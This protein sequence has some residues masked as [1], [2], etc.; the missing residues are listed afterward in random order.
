MATPRR[1]RKVVTVLFCDLVGFTSRAENLDPE[2]VADLLAGYHGRVRSDLER[3][4]G[5]VEKFIGDAVMAVFGAPTTHEDDPER[6]VRAALA[7][8]DWALEERDVQVRIAVNTGEA[9]VTIDARPEEGE[10]V[11]AGDV[12]NTAARLQAVSPVNSILV[13]ETTYRATRH[14]IDYRDSPPVT[15]KGKEEPVAVWEV[16]DARA[17]FGAEVLDHAAGELVGRERELAA[18][19]AALDRVR[20]ERS[21]QLVT[22]VGVPGIGKS[23]LLYELS[24]IA[25]AKPELITWRQGRCLAFG[26]GVTFWALSEIIKAQAGVLEA[27]SESTVTEKLHRAVAEVAEAAEAPWIETRLRPLVGVGEESELGGDRRSET[28]A[29]WRRY[30]EELAA[31]RPLVLVFEDLQWADDGL[32]DFVDELAEWTSGVP[33]LVVCTARP[34]LLARRPDWAGGKLNASTIALEPLSEEETARL[35][36]GLLDRPVLPTDVQR[37]LLDRAGGNPLYAEQFAQLY[38]ERG[39]AEE[40]PLPET[41]HGIIAARLDGLS[42]DEK[43]LLQSAAVVGKVFWTGAVGSNGSDVDTVLHSLERKGFVRRQRRSS[44]AGERE[45]AFAH[46]LVRDVA[47]GQIPRRERSRK[48]RLVAEWTV[49]LG[50]PED[51]A[52]MVAHH[53]R[54]ALELA[55]AA[56]QDVEEL[57]ERTRLAL[58]DAGDRASSLNA[59]GQAEGYYRDALALSADGDPERPQLLFRLAR[60]LHLAERDGQE[61]ALET[62]REALL[63]AGYAEQTAEAE[64]FLADVAWYQGNQALMFD[65]L[66]EASRLLEGAQPS[67]A[68]ARVLAITARRYVISGRLEGEQIAR[69][70]LELAEELGLDELRAHALGTIGVAVGRR[71]ETKEGISVTQRALEIALAASSPHAVTLANNLAS[72][73][74]SSGDYRRGAELWEETWALERRFGLSEMD[75]FQQGVRVFILFDT[76]RWD[77]A[78]ALADAFI[79]EAEAGSP[80]YQRANVQST[81]GAIRLARGD[82]EGALEDFRQAEAF[83]REA[84]DPQVV[85]TVLTALT[86]G[87]SDLGLHEDARRVANEIMP[88]AREHPV[89]AEGLSWIAPMAADLGIEDDLRVVAAL[90]PPSRWREL[91]ELGLERRF[92]DAIELLDQ[93]GIIA[94]AAM[95]RLQF[96]ETLMD[97]GRRTQAERELR[98]ALAFFRTVDATF[99]VERGEAL[100]AQAATG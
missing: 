11:A 89:V 25:D 1:E 97:S 93:M 90:M 56:G 96:A 71:G 22:L 41:L 95:T 7:I 15:A 47:Y 8:R 23:R 2:D 75:R 38:L 50:R 21:P 49:S 64:A 46:A 32:L 94:A 82:T 74:L 36:A 37:T 43:A 48:H 19:T 52:E 88:I 14:A 91:L 53:L 72:L 59:F 20:D 6:A 79:A 99:Y 12:V 39:S 4:G 27:D 80:H 66:D 40:L 24:L 62:A 69:G 77:E 92:H 70:A 57:E 65:R 10:G 5:T 30:L 13:G 44:V 26:D 78:L 35:M 67:A 18:L 68:K 17:R 55:R 33:L 58:R 29:A 16:V 73:V 61:S 85:L 31:Q 100:L 45:L 76:G 3:Y 42:P 51:H 54:S 34:E 81:R 83:A 63:A 60:A 9:V 84:G 98:Q 86:I 87:Y 28:F